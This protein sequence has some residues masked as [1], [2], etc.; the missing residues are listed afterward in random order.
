MAQRRKTNID[1]TPK[2]AADFFPPPSLS[3]MLSLASEDLV[4]LFTVARMARTTVGRRPR[5]PS[6]RPAAAAAAGA[7]PTPAA[8][9]RGAVASAVAR[10]SMRRCRRRVSRLARRRR[11]TRLISRRRVTRLISWRRIPWRIRRLRGRPS[12]AGPRLNNRLAQFQRR[13][14]TAV[15]LPASSLTLT[16]ALCL[17]LAA[18]RRLPRAKGMPAGTSISVLSGLT[19]ATRCLRTSRTRSRST[20]KLRAGRLPTS[21]PRTRSARKPCASGCLPAG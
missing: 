8:A 14:A 19:V 9:T 11:V 5:G 15:N 12:I 13:F 20:C 16:L 21:G 18:P 6:R 17:A 10:R 3:S 1:V 4:L 7:A 2:R